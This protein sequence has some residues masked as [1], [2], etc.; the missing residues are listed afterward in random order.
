MLRPAVP[1]GSCGGGDS[2]GGAA[3]R[4]CQVSAGGQTRGRRDCSC[5]PALRWLHASSLRHPAVDPP[6]LPP[7]PHTP[8]HPTCPYASTRA[9][10]VHFAPTSRAALLRRLGGVCCM[11]SLPKM[12][13]WWG[14]AVVLLNPARFLRL[15]PSTWRRRGSV[16]VCGG[17]GGGGG[18]QPCRVGSVREKATRV[19]CLPACQLLHGMFPS[20]LFHNHLPACI[21]LAPDDRLP[22]P[23]V[24][25]PAP[26]TCT[27]H[28]G[29][30]DRLTR[31]PATPISCAAISVPTAADRLGAMRSICD[32]R[33]EGGG[34]R[35]WQ[36]EL[37][38]Q[39]THL[40][41]PPTTTTA[42]RNRPC[43]VNKGGRWGRVPEARVQNRLPVPAVS[44]PT[45]LRSATPTPPAPHLL[46][47]QAQDEVLVLLQLQR[48]LTRVHHLPARASGGEAG[49]HG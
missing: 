7:P 28:A 3:A 2:G 10:S 25:P 30:L 13:P 43:Q 35:W 40:H 32:K 5:R 8:P 27:L 38:R 45:T 14:C 37:P 23:A 36:E 12:K 47:H 6:P 20:R 39:A 29:I 41:E 34:K 42:A 1:L 9:S 19:A 46:L 49:R 44:R 33:R 24:P 48:H 22:Y 18:V 11:M 4:R 21:L 31:P 26:H 17:W 16:C 15:A